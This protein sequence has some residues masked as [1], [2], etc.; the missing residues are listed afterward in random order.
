MQKS[1]T[2]PAVLGQMKNPNK[3][4]VQC[5]VEQ[6]LFQGKGP[7]VVCSSWLITSTCSHA[8]PLWGVLSHNHLGTE[9]ALE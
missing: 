7:Y 1:L 6:I 9:Q 2:P 8:S 3:E 4:T 5:I